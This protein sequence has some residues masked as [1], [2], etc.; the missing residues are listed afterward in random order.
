VCACVRVCLS[1]SGIEGGEAETGIP[2]S[3]RGSVVLV[4]SCLS[5]SDNAEEKF[6]LSLST[7]RRKVILVV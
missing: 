4:W 3:R 1:G 5:L 2:R 7:D 6:R